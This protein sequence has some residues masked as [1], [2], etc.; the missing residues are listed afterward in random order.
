MR[1]R[2]ALALL[3]VGCGDDSIQDADTLGVPDDDM[4]LEDDDLPA[5][6]CRG[7]DTDT[8]TGTDTDPCESGS[9]AFGEDPGAP[10]PSDGS[11]AC[12]G[13][14]DCMGGVCAASFDPATLQRSPLACQFACVPLI[15]DT[16][17]CSDDA[18]CCDAG[19]L[20][21]E[22]GYC[23]LLEGSTTGG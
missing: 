4:A 5:G 17:W 20:C 12:H 8:D 23:V 21:T 3:L 11:D 19:A 18:S 22:R 16:L 1:M 14:V 7:P 2:L 10:G 6:V 15:D 9:T 13:S